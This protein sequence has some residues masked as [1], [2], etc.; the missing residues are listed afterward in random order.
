MEESTCSTFADFSLLSSETGNVDFDVSETQENKIVEEPL[1]ITITPLHHE[2]TTITSNP[3]S[4]NEDQVIFCP[5]LSWKYVKKY[6]KIVKLYAG[7]PTAAEFDFIVNGL[8][9]KH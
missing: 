6:S 8:K 3:S 7:C 4:S 5:R 2:P 1:S 9:P